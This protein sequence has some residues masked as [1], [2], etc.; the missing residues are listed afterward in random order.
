MARLVSSGAELER[1]SPGQNIARHHHAGP[2]AALILGGGYIEAGDRGR[3]STRAGDVVFHAAFEGHCNHIAGT[4]ADILN[5]PMP[6]APE[7]P[8]GVCGDPDAVAR[9][10]ERD[11]RAALELLMATTISAPASVFDWP[12]EL[13]AD[14]RSN[15]VRRLD[16]WAADHGLSPSEVSRG[17][18]TAYGVSPKRFRLELRAA[19][20]ARKIADG[21]RL[22]EAAF[23]AGFSDQPHMTRAI[24]VI[25]GR[26]PGQLQNQSCKSV[27]DRQLR[28]T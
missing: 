12:D 28:P 3:I 7:T 21:A 18:R 1:A 22:S 17:F 2:Y 26:S 20:A 5:L 15:R 23:A 19:R 10:A 11:P 6:A 27:Q 16:W 4:G 9:L 13:A 8:L 25:F 14:L 24:S